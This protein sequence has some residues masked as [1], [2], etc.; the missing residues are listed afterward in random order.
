MTQKYDMDAMP[1]DTKSMTAGRSLCGL[2]RHHHVKNPRTTFVIRGNRRREVHH[3]A[4]F[5]ACPARPH[6]Y[7]KTAR[8]I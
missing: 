3:P 8:R 5:M 1:D 7:A 2:E 6:T 4:N